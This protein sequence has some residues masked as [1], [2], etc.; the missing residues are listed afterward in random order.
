MIYRSFP[1]ILRDPESLVRRLDRPTNVE[2]RA[3]RRL[4]QLTH[5]QLANALPRIVADAHKETRKPLVAEQSADE[6]ARHGRKSVIPAE[7]LIE[8]LPCR[9]RR[10]RH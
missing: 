6:I 7:P 3:A 2:P 10:Q 1:V 5:D 8:R 9:R 4:T